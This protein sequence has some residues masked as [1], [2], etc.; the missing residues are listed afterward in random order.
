M[1]MGGEVGEDG[2]GERVVGFVRE[3]FVSEG[4]IGDV[5]LDEMDKRN[6]DGEMMVRRRGVGGG[7]LGGKVREWKEG[8]DGERWGG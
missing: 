2:G 5:G 3:K 4:M 7:G 1:G 6:G 8:R